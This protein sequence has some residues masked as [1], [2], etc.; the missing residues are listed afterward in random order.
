MVN[1]NGNRG[2][3]NVNQLKKFVEVQK[4]IARLGGG[5]GRGSYYGRRGLYNNNNNNRSGLGLFSSNRNRKLPYLNAQMRRWRNGPEGPYVIIAMTRNGRPIK[6][7][8]SGSPQFAYK[9][10]GWRIIPWTAKYRRQERLA[11]L[12][13]KRAPF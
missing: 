5:Y 1:G 8:A 7:T 11:G 12:R 6:K 3:I 4:E 10:I 13:K 9:N 2:K